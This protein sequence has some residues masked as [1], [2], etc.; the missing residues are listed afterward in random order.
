MNTT[1]NN[2]ENVILRFKAAKERKKAIISELE[3]EM[4]ENY[5]KRTGKKA[6][7]FFSL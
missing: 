1:T 7:Y 3:K 5:E 4:K 2:K 6:N